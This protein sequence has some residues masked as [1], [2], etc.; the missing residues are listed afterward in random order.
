MKFIKFL[1]FFILVSCSPYPKDANNS[2][3]DAKKNKL[4][5][6]VAINPPF[7][8]FKNDSIIGSEIEIIRDFADQE[9]LQIE[10]VK[11][12][13]SDLVEKIEQYQLH[14][15]AGGFDKKTIWK[16]KA[17]PTVPY[18]GHHVLLVPSGENRLLFKLEKFIFNTI[19]R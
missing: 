13:E 3:K 8:M 17:K 5:V 2:F 6:G 14:I 4:K 19:K 16:K 7:T 11:G 9:N 15:I 1:I 18:D 12:T 10:I